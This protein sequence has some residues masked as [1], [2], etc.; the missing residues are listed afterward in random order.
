MS[1]YQYDLLSVGRACLDLYADEVGVPFPEV[2]HFSAYVGGCPANVA[3]SAR[4]LGLRVAMLSAVGED[5]VGDFVLRFL[6]DEGIET[7]YVARKGG[8]RLLSRAATEGRP[9]LRG[10]QTFPPPHDLGTRPATGPQGAPSG[11][12][13][14]QDWPLGRCCRE[15][16]DT[17][18]D[19]CG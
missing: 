10:L 16:P 3:V 14:A 7:R 19:E 17:L 12:M 13:P 15:P 4:R 11:I 9:S 5:L 1:D 18:P 2:E 6:A 8:A